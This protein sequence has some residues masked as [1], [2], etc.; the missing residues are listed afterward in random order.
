MFADLADE[1]KLV[2][3]D[4]VLSEFDEDPFPTDSGLGSRVWT[5]HAF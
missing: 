4:M 3:A 1:K 5:S 2:N